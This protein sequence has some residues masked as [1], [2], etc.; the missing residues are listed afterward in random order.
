MKFLH[1]HL[2]IP[3]NLVKSV[4]KVLLDMGVFSVSKIQE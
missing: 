4:H 3:A 2:P 1:R